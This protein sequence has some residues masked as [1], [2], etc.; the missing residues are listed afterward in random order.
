MVVFEHRPS[1]PTI[2]LFM[3]ADIVGQILQ[4]FSFDSQQ[5]QWCLGKQ[6]N[7]GH[8]TRSLLLVDVSRQ[9][10]LVVVILAMV[11]LPINNL[12]GL[13]AILAKMDQ[14]ICVFILPL[15]VLSRVQARLHLLREVLLQVVQARNVQIC[16]I[17][18]DKAWRSIIASQQAIR[19]RYCSYMKDIINLAMRLQ[20]I[21]L[22]E[23]KSSRQ[24]E[25]NKM[26]LHAQRTNCTFSW[27]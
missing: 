17:T 1:N 8:I 11:K 2:G 14:T 19:W 6:L 16:I 25:A 13:F 15:E 18:V 7:F 21:S 22:K 5:S 9:A 4:A 3:Q 26:A 24:H 10:R 20:S 12:F 27:H 23:W